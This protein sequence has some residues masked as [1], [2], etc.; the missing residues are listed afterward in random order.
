[1]QVFEL[2]ISPFYYIVE[3]FFLLGYK[4]TDDYGVAIILLSF[5]ISLLLLPIFI[6]I[7]RSKKKDDALKRR[8]QPLLA[9]IKRCYKGQERYYYIRTLH[10]QHGYNSFKSLVPVLSL[11]LQ[12][13]FFIAAYQ[14]LEHFEPLA[15]QSF[16][17]INDLSEPDGLLGSIN[18]LPIIMTVVNLVTAYFY[19]RNGDKAERKQMLV[20]A[21]IFLALLYNFPSGLV[22]YWTMNNVFSFFRLFITNPEVFRRSE[23]KKGP[24]VFSVASLKARL[25]PLLP[26]L[27][28][29]FAVLAL[30]VMLSQLHWSFMHNFND[31]ALRIAVTVI[32]SLVLTGLIAL[33]LLA[34]NEKIK[35]GVKKFRG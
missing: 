17:F 24:G 10:R 16:L 25:I 23:R 9:E 34:Y 28:R 12:I 3:Q 5:A 14:F 21:G 8:M 11:L 31:I 30:A 27:L 35:A 1:M 7:E 13:P 18:L 22:L 2:I 4:L 32:G 20:V 33:F 29:V 6:L 26:N 19:T 15:G